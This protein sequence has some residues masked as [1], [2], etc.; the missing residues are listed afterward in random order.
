[1]CVSFSAN[2]WLRAFSIFKIAAEGTKT[3]RSVNV[4]DWASASVPSTASC[5][6]KK[7]Q[8]VRSS[9]FVFRDHYSKSLT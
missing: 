2:Y 3:L 4:T 5:Y 6:Q 8:S 1:M 7:A 9:A